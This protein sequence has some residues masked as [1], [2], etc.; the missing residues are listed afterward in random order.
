MITR[1]RVL[2]ELKH[3]GYTSNCQEAFDQM[4]DDEGLDV[5]TQP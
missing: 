3:H 5:E 1:N 2:L 4:C